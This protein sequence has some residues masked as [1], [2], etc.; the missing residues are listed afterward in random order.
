MR[1]PS[2]SE[3]R[4][5]EVA[6]VWSG[7]VDWQTVGCL[8]EALFDG[9]EVAGKT[10]VHLDVRAVTSIGLGGAALLIGANHRASAVG[11][12]LLIV[13]S[14]GPVTSALT[15]LHILRDFNVTQLIASGEDPGSQ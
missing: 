11:R 9:L 8:R 14:N 2:H 13:D 3:R 4:Q 5:T 15:A 12:S 7:D 6:I 1:S 10:G